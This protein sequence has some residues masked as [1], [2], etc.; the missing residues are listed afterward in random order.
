LF[1]KKKEIVTHPFPFVDLSLCVTLEN[2]LLK[3]TAVSINDSNH[4]ST[5]WHHIERFTKASNW[6]M[7]SGRTSCVLLMPETGRGGVRFPY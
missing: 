5:D 1:K 3:V 2:K 7:G 4:E 6:Q